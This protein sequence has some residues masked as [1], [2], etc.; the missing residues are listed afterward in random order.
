MKA[1]LRTYQNNRGNYTESIVE[2]DDDHDF[3]NSPYVD[4]VPF[5]V[6]S[7]QCILPYEEP[8]IQ[9]IFHV[10]TIP[11]AFMRYEAKQYYMDRNGDKNG[12][13]KYQKSPEYRQGIAARPVMRGSFLKKEDAV[14]TVL[15]NGDLLYEYYYTFVVIETHNLNAID[16]FDFMGTQEVWFQ[17]NNIKFSYQQI[18]KPEYVRH[19]VA[20]AT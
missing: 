17:W 6:G 18:E 12:L 10:V 7:N 11:D 15:L 5:S 20:F 9:R 4:T 13:K 2:I 1:I 3:A 19:I 16:S 8:A 14:N